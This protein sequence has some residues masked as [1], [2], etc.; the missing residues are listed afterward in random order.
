MKS[1]MIKQKYPVVFIP[2]VLLIFSGC[3][4]TY[5]KTMEK[6][7][8]HKRDILVNRVA[9]ARDSQEVAKEQFKSA[10]DKYSSVV[11][12]EGGSLEE[13]Y[14]ALNAEYEKSTNKALL[15]SER[16]KS[17]ENVAKSL[18]DE[19]ETELEQYTS[20]RLRQSSQEKLTQTREQYGHLMDAMKRAERKIDPV[21]SAFRDQVL[22]LKHN[23]NAQ[24]IA[25]LQGELVMVEED[26][27]S[28]IREMEVS[29]DEADL[30]IRS[31]LET[32]YY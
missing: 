32:T 5:Y 14:T 7:G 3:Q 10:L 23:L 15:V 6:L 8:Y 12:F 11:N 31:M 17:V 26:V 9:D 18:F 1:S 22:Y 16:I 25:S 30:F 13:N 19:W 21:L 4:T 20:S 28:L 24:A 2:I 29:I 27:A